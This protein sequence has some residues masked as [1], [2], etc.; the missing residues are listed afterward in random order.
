MTAQVPP[1]DGS[2]EGVLVART[3][4]AH[5]DGRAGRAIIRGF[6]LPELAEKLSYED[7]A[8]VVLTGEQ[9]RDEGERARF[10]QWI[11]AGAA[12]TDAERAAARALADGRSEADALSAAI[13][14]AEDSIARETSDVV[15]RCARVMGRVPSVVAAVAGLPEPPAQWS[16]ARRSLA[17]LGATRDD[18]ASVRA[19]EVLLDLESEHGLSGSTF[20][21]RVAASSGANAGPALAAAVA[22]LSGERH[23]GATAKARA[24]LE[25][26]RDSGDSVA[27]VRAKFQAKE[28][29]P[30]FGHRV[31]KVAD[32]R[33]PPLREAMRR[34]GHAPL[35]DVCE[36]VALAA[37]PLFAPKG[38]YP[39]IDLYG[40]ALLATLGVDPSRY[41]AAFTVGIACGWL[42]H[43]AEVRAVGRLVRPDNEYSGPSQRP[44]L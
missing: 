12:L 29:L 7:V 9:P 3:A 26:A 28:R 27:F 41:V 42:A 24:M 22:T 38:I 18:P 23:G 4:I 36:A 10:A 21:C 40:A 13:V 1:A 31:Y 6:L 32:P 34:M 20:A 15:E 33:V 2:L 5:V 44:V 30:G 14:L 19:L 37:E 11:R 43:W 16:Y 25:A 17:A 8:F 35:L 39:N